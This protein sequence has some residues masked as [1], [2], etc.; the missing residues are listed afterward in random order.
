MRTL[1]ALEERLGVKIPTEVRRYWDMNEEDKFMDEIVNLVRK[2]GAIVSQEL[3]IATQRTLP[4][5]E[6][7]EKSMTENLEQLKD[8]MERVLRVEREARRAMEEQNGKVAKWKERN[9]SC[10]T[11]LMQALLGLQGVIEGRKEGSRQYAEQL[12]AARADNEDGQEAKVDSTDADS[13]LDGDPL[14]SGD[15][16]GNKPREKVVEAMRRHVAFSGERWLQIAQH[17]KVWNVMT[18]SQ[19]SDWR[20][21]R[22]RVF[23]MDNKMPKKEKEELKKVYEEELALRKELLFTQVTEAEYEKAEKLEK[24]EESEDDSNF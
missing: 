11:F 20:R 9:I 10:R 5:L 7:L 2:S 15:D 16:A 23:G 12:A 8:E 22:Q 1:E 18:E 19:W 14:D 3:V 24:G 21:Y 17:L 4:C 6:Q 13:D